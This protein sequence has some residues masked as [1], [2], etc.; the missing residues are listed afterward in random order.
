MWSSKVMAVLV[1]LALTAC[2]TRT[3]ATVVAIGT[4]SIG[5]V[6][7]YFEHDARAD[8]SDLP[9]LTLI[10]GSAVAIVSAISIFV[11][12]DE[13]H[14]GPRYWHDSRSGLYSHHSRSGLL[15]ALRRTSCFGLCPEYSVAIYRD[16]VVEYRGS[17]F[18][19][20]TGTVLGRLELE[21]VRALEE[22]FVNADFL[23]FDRGYVDEDCTDLPTAYV[24]FRPAGRA[25]KVV[26]HYLGDRSAPKALLA[27]E[28]AIDNAVDIEQWI[29]SEHAGPSATYC[30]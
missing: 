11:L 24:G 22:Q 12:E 1:G 9:P 27:L 15:F 26:A 14:E 5:L 23:A 25:M 28:E 3:Q 29:G 10:V 21:Q 16:G 13:P 4:G 19:R 7:G 30:R 6:G 2:Q 17:A 18:V 20:T 8:G